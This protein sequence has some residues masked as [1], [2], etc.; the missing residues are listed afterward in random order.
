[1][2]SK[3][4]VSVR[5]S[6][7]YLILGTLW[8]FFSGQLAE[9]LAGGDV[10]KLQTIERYKGV[11]FILLSTVFLYFISRGFY[12]KMNRSLEEYK[13]MEKKTDAL[14]TA[15][16]EGIYE[17]NIREDRVLF[18]AT[19]RQILG[20]KEEGVIYNGRKFWETHI[21]PDDLQRVLSQSDAAMQA[22]INFWREEYRALSASGEIKNVLHS[23]YIMKDDWGKPFG[24]IGA[25]QDLTEFRQLEANYYQQQL[26]QKAELSRSIIQ[27]EEKERNRWAEELH[28]N[29]AQVLSVASLYAGT[30]KPDSPDIKVTADKIRE[31][32]NL[33]VQE[34]RAL[35]ANLKPPR[36]EE[37]TLQDA[38]QLL[39]SYIVRVSPMK[40]NVWVD[41]RINDLLGTDQKLMIYRIVQEQ[42]NNCVKYAEAENIDITVSVVDTSVQ[43]IIRDDGK[44]FD[45]ATVGEG[46]GMRNIRGRLELFQ[47][48]VVFDAKPG[49]GCQVKASFPIKGGN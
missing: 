2:L 44:G 6:L 42:L 20:I 17:Y 29:I 35:S 18:N 38:L 7:A 31:M 28:D 13:A 33:S 11:F 1:M 15:T 9:K 39:T 12:S 3:I 27:A 47:G 46:T 22:G 34:L 36:F 14:I 24:V 21:H 48:T 49:T 40:I 41:E 45:P 10:N 16:K 19:L 37:Q 23:L 26:K 43:V 5:L 32:L 30:L 4:P 25:I 8:I